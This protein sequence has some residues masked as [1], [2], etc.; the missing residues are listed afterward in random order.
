MWLLYTCG[1]NMLKAHSQLAHMRITYHSIA[2]L[3][4]TESR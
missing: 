4:I 3:N 2:N 1:V